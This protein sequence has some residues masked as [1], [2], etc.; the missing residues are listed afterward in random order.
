MKTQSKKTPSR[1]IPYRNTNG[2]ILKRCLQPV[3]SATT[4]KRKGHFVRVAAELILCPQ[5]ES[6][7]W[8][9]H[10]ET[11]DFFL[12][13]VKYCGIRC[14]NLK[15]FTPHMAYNQFFEKYGKE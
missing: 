9:G 15:Q 1:V 13:H 4:A 7:L 8:I 6:L 3:F 10:C 11:C 14:K 5:S 2:Y 12:G